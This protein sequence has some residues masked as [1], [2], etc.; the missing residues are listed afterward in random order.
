MY[1]ASLLNVMP[2]VSCTISLPS[3]VD[4]V[5]LVGTCLVGMSLAE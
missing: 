4:E 5:P 2:S 1:K 3:V